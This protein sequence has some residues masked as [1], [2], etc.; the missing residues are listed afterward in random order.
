MKLKRIGQ[1]SGFQNAKFFTGNGK[2]IVTQS[3]GT[4]ITTINKTS[5]AWFQKAIPIK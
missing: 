2:M 4:F 5:N 3:D 1:W